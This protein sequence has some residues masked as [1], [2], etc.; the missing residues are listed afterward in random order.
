MKHDHLYLIGRDIQEDTP[1]L[2]Q[3]RI[4][5]QKGVIHSA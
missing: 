5:A 2:M 4:N 3:F 1:D